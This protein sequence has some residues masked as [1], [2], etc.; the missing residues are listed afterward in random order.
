WHATRRQSF[1]ADEI[2]WIEN[3][4]GPWREATVV[5]L[6]NVRVARK[7]PPTLVPGT[8][9]EAFRTRI[10]ALELEAE[11][12]Q[13]EAMYAFEHA[14]PAGTAQGTP[15]EAARTSLAGYET[16]CRAPYPAAACDALLAA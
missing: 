1:T 13:Q 7:R 14:A 12:L 3:K 8:T 2:A 9:A 11:R 6:R 15:A 10:K 5:P 4:I 16:I